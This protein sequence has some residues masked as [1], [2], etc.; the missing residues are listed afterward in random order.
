MGQS[1]IICGKCLASPMHG[2]SIW[3]MLTISLEV[4]MPRFRF[5]IPLQLPSPFPPKWH[6]CLESWLSWSLGS[7]HPLS[8]QVCSCLRAFALAVSSACFPLPPQ[9]CSQMSSSEW[10]I[11][12]LSYIILECFHSWAFFLGNLLLSNTVNSGSFI[13]LTITCIAL[14]MG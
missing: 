1:E 11:L 5:Q 4:P 14:S 3:S 9:V 12:W 8:G 10:R 13:D 6:V 2:M 7:W